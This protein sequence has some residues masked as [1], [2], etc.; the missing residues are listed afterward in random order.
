MNRKKLKSNVELTSTRTTLRC[1][2]CAQARK[3]RLDVQ[4]HLCKGLRAVEL[5][6][7]VTVTLRLAT[8]LPLKL[9]AAHLL[10]S[11]QPHL[12][13]LDSNDP[14]HRQAIL[15]D[16]AIDGALT[17]AKRVGRQHYAMHGARPLM[18][19]AKVE[20]KGVLS[21]AVTSSKTGK[22]R[23]FDITDGPDGRIS[24][25]SGSVHSRSAR[26]GPAPGH[27][28]TNYA[29]E[30]PPDSIDGG[31]TV[32]S[33]HLNPNFNASQG[34]LPRKSYGRRPSRDDFAPPL[35][36]A[37]GPGAG[38]GAGSAAGMGMGMGMPTASGMGM[39]GGMGIGASANS[40]YDSSTTSTTSTSRKASSGFKGF[41]R[42]RGGG[43]A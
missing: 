28:G 3:G 29:K 14:E 36:N 27:G 41:F 43:M 35:P 20:R 1:P 16:R 40:S 5:V 37:S 31:S 4:C 12:N 42:G 26:S 33:L 13:Y 7:V 22:R 10:G 32:L 21:V 15:K 34:S 38:T 25:T 8:F 24:E 19:R 2:E 18:A 11:R 9:P 6:Y 17:A 30:A 23:T 39:G